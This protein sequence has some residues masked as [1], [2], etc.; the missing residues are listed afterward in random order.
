VGRMCKNVGGSVSL[1][2]GNDCT[3]WIRTCQK[4]DRVVWAGRLLFYHYLRDVAHYLTKNSCIL[5][6][7]IRNIYFIRDF[8]RFLLL[9]SF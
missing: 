8:I 4:N 5:A 1:D 9:F 3:G 6:N 7:Q 2:N